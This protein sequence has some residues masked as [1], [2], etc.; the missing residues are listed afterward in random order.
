MV[1]NQT[2][3]VIVKVFADYDYVYKV[4]DYEY[5]YITSGNGD[6]DYEYWRLCNRLQS[7]TIINY[8]Y[9][10]LATYTTYSR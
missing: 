10:N 1:N 2:S 6:N 5:D 7:I 3:C 8:D 9:L 4:I